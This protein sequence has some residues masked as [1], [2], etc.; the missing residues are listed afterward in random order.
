MSV[1]SDILGQVNWGF[2]HA[3]GL[4]YDEIRPIPLQ[5]YKNHNLP[6]KT[7]CSGWI[8]C[9]FYAGGGADPGGGDFNGS[10]NTSSMYS[11]LP[12]IPKAD[13]LPG[14]IIVFG[15]GGSNHAVILLQS[16]K[17]TD[18]MTG[19]NGAEAG[20]WAARLTAEQAA[21]RSVFGNDETTFLR[22]LPTEPP[23]PRHKW[24]VYSKDGTFH[25]TTIHP[26]LWATAH[27]RKFRK[28]WNLEY[29]RRY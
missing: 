12:H 22:A 17:T 10:G 26:A 27:P 24:D 20:P 29:H 8:I 3:A 4:R 2:A 19:S 28:L 21:Q 5:S 23:P 6:M 15:P 16:G 25:D 9:C 13:A 11:H 18:P 14:D 7:D 1:R